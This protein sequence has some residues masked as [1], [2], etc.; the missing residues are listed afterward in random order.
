MGRFG[1]SFSNDNSSGFRI[2]SRKHYAT[3]SSGEEKKPDGLFQRTLAW[4]SYFVM[5]FVAICTF[6]SPAVAA[7]AQTSVAPVV[8]LT[9]TIDEK[10]AIIRDREVSPWALRGTR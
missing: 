6:N 9:Q 5:V 8:Y 10:R 2:D 4:A 1:I 7:V 3:V